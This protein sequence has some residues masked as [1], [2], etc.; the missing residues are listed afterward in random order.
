MNYDD[1]V[2]TTV[3]VGYLL[4]VNGAEIYRA[5]E[6]MRRIFRAY[7]VNSGEVF[8]I[9]TFLNVSISTPD[10]HPVTQIKRIPSREMDM[11]K[12]EQVNDLCRRICRSTPDF[13]Y[14][15]RELDRINSRRTFSVPVQTAAYAFIAFF[16]T[17]FYGGNIV[18]AAVALLCG[19]VIKPV[20]YVLQ[21][22]NVNM[23]FVNIA[24]AFFATVIAMV[25]THVNISLNYDKIIIGSLMNLVPGITI[26]GFMR[27][28]IA[29]DLVAGII[30]F[31]QSLLVATAIAIGSG[32]ALTASRMLWGV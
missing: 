28:I 11:D 2:N 21:R 18:D 32:I 25:A 8:V 16:F 26:T 5:E 7:G 30:R 12:V 4:V 27:D 17:L 14:I 31:T 10:G 13:A 23:F 19:A 3:E 1:L 22:F 15:R 24:A 6:S 20:C 9:P 29:G